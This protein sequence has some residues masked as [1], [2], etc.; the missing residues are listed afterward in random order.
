MCQAI[1][2]FSMYQPSQHQLLRLQCQQ[3]Q[4]QPQRHQYT[5]GSNSENFDKVL[6]FEK[7]MTNSDVHL[8]CINL[9]SNTFFRPQPNYYN[10]FASSFPSYSALPQQTPS[11][12]PILPAVSNPPGN[13][14]NVPIKGSLRT[15]ITKIWVHF[16]ISVF[17]LIT[18]MVLFYILFILFSGRNPIVWWIWTRRGRWS[19]LYLLWRQETRS[20]LW[21]TNISISTSGNLSFYLRKE[22]GGI[23]FVILFLPFRNFFIITFYFQNDISSY[24]VEDVQASKAPPPEP[25]GVNVNQFNAPNPNNIHTVYVPFENA[26]NVPATYD[27][28]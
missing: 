6:Q 15:M 4:H 22:I 8:F 25:S 14:Y 9:S 16:E 18:L 28:R 10:Q 2:P 23:S 20:I 7:Y 19:I 13:V 11:Q 24:I 3:L 17:N 21:S 5:T 12:A 27:V 26:V 1:H